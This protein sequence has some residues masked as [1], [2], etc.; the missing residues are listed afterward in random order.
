MR[1]SLPAQTAAVVLGEIRRGRWRGWLPGERQ[2]CEE[3]RVSRGTLRGAL[4]ILQGQRAL[5]VVS[6]QG[7]QILRSPRR[8]RPATERVSIGVLSPEPLE[9]QRPFFG[10]MMDRLCESAYGRG[11]TVQRHYRASCFGPKAEANLD[12]LAVDFPSTCWILVRANR[13]AQEWFQ[14]RTLPAIVSG[15]TYP[16][17]TLPSLDGDHR[18]VG[19]HAGILLT[20]QGHEFAA[21]I[22]SRE[23][24]PGLIEGEAGFL[25]GFRHPDGSESLILRVS[26]DGDDAALA[27][28]IT[29]IFRQSTRPTAVIT[30]TSNQY[31]VVLS[32]LAQL[33]LVVPHDVSL[34]SRLD[35]TYLEHLTPVPTRYRVDP[36]GFARALTAMVAHVVAGEKLPAVARMIIP[37]FIKGASIARPSR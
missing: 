27:G 13:R 14:Q 37:D 17:V 20:R 25:D 5:K 1:T 7:H 15:H 36:A 4:A 2:L 6:S 11:W 21:L 29:R 28:A 19:R 33:R 12:M 26:D 31:L 30:E 10:L 16:S 32:A 9:T 35:D 24:L 8:A 23:R 3:L 18:A 22:V 34:V